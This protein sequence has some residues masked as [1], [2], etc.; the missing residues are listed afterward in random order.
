MGSGGMGTL[1]GGRTLSAHG[2]LIRGTS[3]ARSAEVREPGYSEEET[4]RR[5]R[6]AR[7]P[8]LRS[9][10]ERRFLRQERLSALS[11]VSRTTVYRLEGGQRGAQA[12]TAWRL[13]LALG[14]SPEELVHGERHTRWRYL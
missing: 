8:H 5:M 13:A 3:K 9:I 2:S 1:P 11:G 6:G 7:L 14:V 4:P 10:R 12:R